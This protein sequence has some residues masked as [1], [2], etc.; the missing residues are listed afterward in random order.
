LRRRDRFYDFLFGG[1]PAR[2]AITTGI[3]VGVVVGGVFA[4]LTVVSG[5]G[6]SSSAGQIGRTGPRGVTGPTGARGPTGT[7]GSRGSNPIR[8]T[9]HR[10]YVVRV[11]VRENRSKPAFGGRLHVSVSSIGFNDDGGLAVSFYA[12]L[13][14]ATKARNFRMKSVGFVTKVG[15]YRIRVD[16]LDFELSTAAFVISRPRK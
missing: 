1:G 11:E 13:S 6:S 9:R 3:I 10:K 8:Q 5:N 15:P 16:A 4:V 2:L 14:G 7:P 12:D